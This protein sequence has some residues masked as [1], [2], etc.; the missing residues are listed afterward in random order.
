LVGLRI[1]PSGDYAVSVEHDHDLL[2]LDVRPPAKRRTIGTK[3]APSALRTHRLLRQWEGLNRQPTVLRD[4]LSNSTSAERSQRD[5]SV[6]SLASSGGF[7][8]T[9]D[10]IESSAL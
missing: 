3:L 7:A 2:L 4:L 1:E 6:Q 5:R 9:V 10:Y 8:G